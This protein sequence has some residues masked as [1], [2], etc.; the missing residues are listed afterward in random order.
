MTLALGLTPEQLERR[1]RG[2]GGS[3]ANILMKGE[4]DPILKL[5]LQKR[6]ELPDDDL[7]DVLPV[8]MGHWTEELNVMWF[9]KKTGF[10]VK[11]RGL[12][13]A[14]ESYP[15]IMCTLDGV[16]TLE[17]GAD[18]VLECKH[19]NPFGYSMDKLVET[20]Y[21]QLQHNMMTTG[22]NRAAISVFVGNLVWDY[23]IVNANAE[24]QGQM[25]ERELEFWGC[26]TEARRPDFQGAVETP[27]RPGDEI[28]E[29]SA[30]NEWGHYASDWLAME[31][32]AKKFDEAAKKLK[33]L[34]PKDTRIAYG[35][36]ICIRRGKSGLRITTDRR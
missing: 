21:P 10:H 23:S 1:R 29:M 32:P 34:V 35:C 24:Y 3:D 4:Q 26:V 13:C 2:I 31:K 36:G 16:A 12:E 19:V 33:S 25:L 15:Q 18:V 22:M 14:H 30:S 17:D 6:G 7:S 11:H 8:Q 20:Y 9:T 28:M 5:W 27:A